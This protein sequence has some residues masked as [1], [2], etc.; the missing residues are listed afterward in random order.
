MVEHKVA[1]FYILA[2]DFYLLCESDL[3]VHFCHRYYFIAIPQFT[4]LLVC[5]E[6]EHS[7][8]R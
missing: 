3:G 5:R 2:W 6:I 4:G 7:L 8:R 1:I